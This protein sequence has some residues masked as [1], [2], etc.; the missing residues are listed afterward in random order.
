[1]KAVTLEF[2]LRVLRAFAD[3]DATDD[4]W[5]RTDAEYAPVTFL[6]N[7]NDLFCWGS[8]DA[9]E[10]TSENVSV[11]EQAVAD[12]RAV[13]GDEAYA[14][15]LFAARVRRERPQGAAYPK[16]RALWPLFDQCG[17]ERQTGLGNPYPPGGKKAAG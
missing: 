15:E 16:N 1:M 4:L 8:A 13:T 6:V 14:C 7:C 10:V 17:S 9:E 11:F 12:V 5:W 2:V 3:A